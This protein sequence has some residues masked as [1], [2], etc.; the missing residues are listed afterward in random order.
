MTWHMSFIETLVISCTVSDILVPISQRSI[1]TLKMTSK[2]HSTPI[3]F[4]DS[5]RTTIK[6][7]DAI[8][9]DSTSLLLNKVK[10]LA[11]NWVGHIWFPR[12]FLWTFVNG[13][14]YVTYYMQ[15]NKTLI[16]WWTIDQIQPLENSVTLIWPFKV[17]GHKVNW[18]IIC[19]FVYVLHVSIGHG[20]HHFWYIALIR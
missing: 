8:Q 13:R 3:E 19:D 9:L 4:E 7:Y 1:L 18:E 10:G 17:K 20:M 14:P 16:I 11:V 12:C 2:M 5:I 6:S 15:F